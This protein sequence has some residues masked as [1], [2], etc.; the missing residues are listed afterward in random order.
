MAT[1][2]SAVVA[3]NWFG[4]FLWKLFVAAPCR[5]HSCLLYRTRYWSCGA[6]RNC[7]AV[8]NKVF[9]WQASKQKETVVQVKFTCSWWWEYKAL[10]CTTNIRLPEKASISAMWRAGTW[11]AELFGSFHTV[12]VKCLGC[13]SLDVLRGRS[14]SDLSA[15]CK[16]WIVTDLFP[17]HPYPRKNSNEFSG[18]LWSLDMVLHVIYR[19]YR[20]AVLWCALF[21]SVRKEER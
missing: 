4:C 21:C 14:L 10:W 19:Q 12:R 11:F 3:W 2:W 7:V 9:F 20:G 6:G 1:R 18:L 16:S 8:C 15:S 17:W 13:T 5:T